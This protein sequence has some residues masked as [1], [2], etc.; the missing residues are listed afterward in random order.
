MVVENTFTDIALVTCDCQ[1]FEHQ[2]TILNLKIPFELSE[3]D[4]LFKNKNMVE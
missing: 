1:K 4:F 3:N 2:W